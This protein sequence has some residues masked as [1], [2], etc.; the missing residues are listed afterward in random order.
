MKLVEFILAKKAKDIV[1][2][3]VRGVSDLCDYFVICSG[4]SATQV[5]AIYQEVARLSRENKIDIQHYEDDK[6]SRWILVDFFD[7][8]LHIFVS[9]ARNFYNLEY[10]WNAAK[11]VNPVRKDYIRKT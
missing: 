2:L 6:L 4:D 3:D 1:V 7:V 11:K 8:I 9:E 10:L 5:R